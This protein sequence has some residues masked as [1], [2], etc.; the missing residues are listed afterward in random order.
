MKS[1]YGERKEGNQTHIYTYYTCAEHGRL[2]PVMKDLCPKC[3]TEIEVEK[4]AGGVAAVNVKV[5]W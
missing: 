2:A 3:G 5:L 4:K 1:H